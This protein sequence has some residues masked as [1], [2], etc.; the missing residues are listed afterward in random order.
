MDP[1]F[2]Y[3]PIGIIH[4]P[5]TRAKA[6]HPGIRFTKMPGGASTCIRN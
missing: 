4:S 1:A 2:S 3:S 6:P 5:F